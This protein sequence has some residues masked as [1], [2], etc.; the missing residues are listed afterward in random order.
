M[1]ISQIQSPVIPQGMPQ[2][3]Q[4]GASSPQVSAI[5]EREVVLAL[6]SVIAP[7]LQAA[8]QAQSHQVGAGHGGPQLAAPAVSA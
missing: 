3:R 7:W 2:S 1:P 4:A 6:A 8:E 5:A